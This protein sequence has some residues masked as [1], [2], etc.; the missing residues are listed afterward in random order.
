[1][2]SIWT[3]S[4]RGWPTD[5][6]DSETSDSQAETEDVLLATLTTQPPAPPKLL[7]KGLHASYFG[8]YLLNLPA[9]YASLDASRPWL[10]YWCLHGF[11]LLGVALDMPMRQRGVDTILSFQDPKGGF[12]GGPA[13]G[14]QA[15]LLPTYA[16]V[17]A[18]AIL[19]VP[20]AWEQI[21]R[22]GM[23]E[24]FMHCKRDDGSFVVCQGGEVDVRCQTYEGGFASAAWPTGS[25]DPNMPVAAAAAEAHG[26]YTSC[27][28]FSHFLL[29]PGC[30]ASSTAIADID[31]HALLRWAV[32]QQ[33]SAMEGG[34]FRGRTNKL[35]DGCYGWWVGGLFAVLESLVRGEDDTDDKTE[36]SA[37]EEW[38]D[39]TERG[40]IALQEYILIAA[41]SMKGGLCDKPGKNADLY[42]STNNLSGLSSAQHFVSHSAKQVSLNRASWQE[43]QPP[44]WLADRLEA[45]GESSAETEKRRK[46]VWANALGWVEDAEALHI[47]GGEESRVN[48]TNPVFNILMLRVKPFV[49]YFYE[50]T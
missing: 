13:P 19:N 34:G 36:S 25:Q 37:D 40:K 8:K 24:F 27:A 42:H 12:A 26:G 21:D 6:V 9:P 5:G 32:M 17:M 11:D 31:T 20:E 50:Q 29:R 23:Y 22:K 41:Q 48:T 10:M 35:V 30:T 46:E 1:M 16:S 2:A 38:E 49:N 4:M 44:R 39:E 33:A 47:V 15:H 14:H 28:L 43:S 3:Q 45:S 7:A 18:L